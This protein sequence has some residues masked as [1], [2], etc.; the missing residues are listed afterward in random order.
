MIKSLEL[1]GIEYVILEKS[2]F[3]QLTESRVGHGAKGEVDAITF[4]RELLA[5]RL[6]AAMKRAGWNQA[7]VA[8]RARVRVET[9]SR[10]MNRKHTVDAT[11]W[12]KIDAAFRRVK[13]KV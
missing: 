8:K 13:V 11:T 2:E 3:E 7:D 12:D 6:S 9:I 1:N 5:D 10:I 4:T